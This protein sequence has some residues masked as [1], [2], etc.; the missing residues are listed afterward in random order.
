M[1]TPQSNFAC[2]TSEQ[3]SDFL[4]T[5]LPIYSQPILRDVRPT[6]MLSAHISS[7]QWDP[8]SGVQQYVDRFRNVQPN[9]TAKWEDVTDAACSTPCDPPMHE[10]CWG[11]ERVQYGQKFQSWRS[12]TLCFDQ[13]IS[14]TKAVEHTAQIVS[15]ILRPASARITSDFARRENLNNS[16]YLKLADA[17][18]SDFTYSWET[19]GGQ[20]IYMTTNG[21]PTSL[22]TPEMLQRQVQLLRNNGYFG[23]QT[24][25]PFWG[26]YDSLIEFITD[27]DT[28]W[29]LD[30]I[31]TNVRISDQ[32]R[33]QVWTAAHEYFKY[34]MGGQL[35]NYMIHI[36]PFPLRFNRV[37]E[38]RFQRV[39]PYRNDP[40][41]VGIGSEVSEDYLN[42][43]YQISTIFH[44]FAWQL[45][46]QRME[47]VNP[48]MPFMVRD[49]GGTWN[50]ATNDL[51]ADCNGQPIANFRKNKGFF[52]A[53]WRL[54]AKPQHTEWQMSIFH[55]RELRPIYVV[56]P[57]GADPGYPT[58]DYNSA[59][60]NC[61]T[62]YTFFSPA[63][64]GTQSMSATLANGDATVTV[65]DTSTL[66]AGQTV[67]GTGIPASTTILSITDGTTFELSANATATGASTLTFGGYYRIEANSTTCG[68]EPLD[69]GLITALSLATLV[70]ALNSD[71]ALGAV[72]TW[73]TADGNLIVSGATCEPVLNF[74]EY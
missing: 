19:D 65:A 63:L 70:T 23:A 29:N 68:S 62:D 43:R 26:G 61:D 42:A 48:L 2:L 18:M 11:W 58:Q 20:E 14:A 74:V 12:Q 53:D 31:A 32:W 25:D 27:D 64:T 1:P 47:S 49:L 38:N 44:R 60:D 9:T 6:D 24:N 73:S 55:Q 51:G 56:A 15:D 7:G 54:A 21:T 5:Q 33:Y 59:C 40:T 71:G 4:L 41:T 45:Q 30:K 52:W 46:T 8:F 67:T 10:I 35:G 72:G 57:C 22:V 13:M 39:L 16:R 69:N 50:F 37:S 36:D 3:Y 66:F 34:G 28:A 17:T